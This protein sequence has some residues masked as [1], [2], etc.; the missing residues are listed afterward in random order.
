MKIIND[1]ITFDS[2]DVA[3]LSPGVQK[4]LQNH[5]GTNTDGNGNFIVTIE[6]AFSDAVNNI[7]ISARKSAGEKQLTNLDDFAKAFAVA[8]DTTK[9]AAQALLDQA[10]A[11]VG[12]VINPQPVP[13]LALTPDTK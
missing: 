12:V 8:D 2:A 1:T 5:V 7:V 10:A 3:L 13:E 9:A 11:V 4:V 6:Q